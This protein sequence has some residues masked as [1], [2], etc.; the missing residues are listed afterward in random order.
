[1]DKACVG[2]EGWNGQGLCRDRGLEWTMLIEGW[3]GQG[4]CCRW[5]RC[6]RIL[7]SG[8]AATDGL[9]WDGKGEG[10]GGGEGDGEDGVDR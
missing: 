5:T 2:I 1:M 6:K 7:H 10:E 9:E 4:L 3:N 8:I